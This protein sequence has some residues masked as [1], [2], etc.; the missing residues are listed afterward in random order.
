MNI[1]VDQLDLS[2]FDSAEHFIS[3]AGGGVQL[4][5]L[6]LP[7]AVFEASPLGG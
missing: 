4:Q 7:P 5:L 6:S 2:A 3:I 1:D